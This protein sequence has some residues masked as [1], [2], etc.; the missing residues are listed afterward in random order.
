[1]SGCCREWQLRLG[2][3]Y[4]PGAA[5][6]AVRATRPDGTPVVLKLI[7]PHRESE[8]EAEALRAWDGD[9]AV[10]LLHHDE[11]RWAM[12]LERCEPGTYLSSVGQD[13]AL[14]VMVE[15]LPR[16]WKPVGAAFRPLAEEAAWWCEIMPG[17]P[18]L[19]DTAI[20]VLRELVDSQGEQ[21]L[22]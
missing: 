22:V 14:D 13:A 1:V 10:R 7:Y 11:A 21:V 8:H 9:G 18:A 3:A 6:D 12:L 2:E 15:L 16:L 20:G 4:E 5:G 17:E 19:R